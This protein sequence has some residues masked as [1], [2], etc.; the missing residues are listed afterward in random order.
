MPKKK[1]RTCTL[2]QEHIDQIRVRWP[3][4]R[5]AMR[6]LNIHDFMSTDAFYRVVRGEKSTWIE[7]ETVKERLIFTLE[8][9][10]FRGD[11]LDALQ[12]A[13]RH[14][15]NKTNKKVFV[16]DLV[17]DIKIHDDEKSLE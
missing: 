8:K 1:E 12:V 15:E 6:A 2:S 14:L 11:I 17:R 5:D 9:N 16:I 3:K 13:A 10:F 7:V 4:L